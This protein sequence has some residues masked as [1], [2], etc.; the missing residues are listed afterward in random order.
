MDDTGALDELASVASVAPTLMVF[1]TCAALFFICFIVALPFAA[2]GVFLPM[3]S[4]RCSLMLHLSDQGS[5]RVLRAKTAIHEA[6]QS[7]KRRMVT[8]EKPVL[9]LGPES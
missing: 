7:L 2:G 8:S 6:I 1:G 5:L 3:T 4:N 9:T